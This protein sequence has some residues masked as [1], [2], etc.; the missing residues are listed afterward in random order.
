[1]TCY[2]RCSTDCSEW[3]CGG[4]TLVTIEEFRK[5]YDVF[6]ITIGF[7]RYF[8]MDPE[9]QK[10]LAGIG[11]K[12]GS[13]YIV[14]DF[15]AG[16]RHKRRCIALGKDNLCSLHK[17]SKKPFQCHIVP[18]CAIYPENR[19]DVIFNEQ[20]AVK[21]A[22]CKGYRAGEETG[23][24][25]WEN[26]RFADISYGEAFHSFQ[27]GLI[28]QRPVME[29]VLEGLKAQ[30]GFNEFLKGSGILETHI[31]ANMLFNV[32]E[33]AEMP[34]E[35]YHLFINLQGRLCYNE[36]VNGEKENLVLADY[37][38]TLNKIAKSYSRF[39]RRKKS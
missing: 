8:A 4:A 13:S 11:T 9:H 25:A 35:E 22:G 24:V 33:A 38:E 16:N 6:P 17:T 1:M 3:C 14:G 2:F 19:Q 10:F 23:H 31:P 34:F 37:L 26:G 21:F 36:L 18:F 27:R 5:C 7:R 20:K 30:P 39:T 28:K 15:I 32:L 29:A 12:S